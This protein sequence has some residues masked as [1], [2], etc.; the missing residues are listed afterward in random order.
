MPIY[1]CGTFQGLFAD[2]IR[3]FLSAMVCDLEIKPVFFKRL[4][5]IYIVIL[6]NKKYSLTSHSTGG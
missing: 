5:E 4:I 2:Y 6:G 1:S 3:N